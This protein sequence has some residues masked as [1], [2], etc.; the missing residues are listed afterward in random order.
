MGKSNDLRRRIREHQPSVEAQPQ[1]RAWL[2]Q[3]ELDRRIIEV[4]CAQTAAC[5][6]KRIETE[7]IAALKGDGHELLNIAENS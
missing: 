1:L 4:W 3:C 2:K 7:L 5:D 6:A